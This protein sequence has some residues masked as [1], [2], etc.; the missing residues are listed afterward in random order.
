[1]FDDRNLRFDLCALGLLAVTVF[2]GL[3]LLTYSPADPLGEAVFPL[4]RVYRPHQVEYPTNQ[5]IQNAC[6]HAGALSADLLLRSFGLGA[7]AV[8][9]LMAIADFL[10]LARSSIDGAATRVAGPHGCFRWRT[11]CRSDVSAAHRR[12]AG[13]WSWWSNRRDGTHFSGVAL[14]HCW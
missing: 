6:G 10:M 12:W 7:Y 9:L 11:H 1:M 5:T 13:N 2:L 14:C 8:V 3:S 4:N